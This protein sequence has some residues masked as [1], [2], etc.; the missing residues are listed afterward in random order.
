MPYALSVSPSGHVLLTLDTLARAG[1]GLPE[2]GGRDL[3]VWGANRE[4]QLGN[5]KRASL[6]TP[7]SLELPGF[8]GGGGPSIQ[9]DGSGEKE[10]G[11]FMLLQRRAKE[12]KDL[13][14][15]RWKTNVD[16][17][18]CAVAGWGGSLVYW[19]ISRK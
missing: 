4:Y 2:G 5:G 7:A 13:Q 6:A 10:K 17:E 18:Q 8:P 16:V 14:G 12:V 11:R 1:P 9:Q 19:K 3:L 15:R